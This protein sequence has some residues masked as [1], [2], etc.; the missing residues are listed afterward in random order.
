MTAQPARKSESKS[1]APLVDKA[2]N[3]RRFG[4]GI[5]MKFILPTGFVITTMMVV[6]GMVL[7][8]G[9][10]SALEASIQESGIFAASAAATPD[11]GKPDNRERLKSILTDRVEDVIIW[12]VAETGGEKFIASATGR[13]Q[14]VMADD[15]AGPQ[16]APG[17]AVRRGRMKNTRDEWIPYRSF[18]KAITAAATGKTIGSVEVLLSEEAIERDLRGLMTTSIVVTVI[19]IILAIGVAYFVAGRITRPLIDLIGDVEIVTQGDFKHRTR[20]RTNDEVGMLA[21]TFDRMTRELA[22]GIDMKADLDRKKHQEQ[23]AQEIQEKLLPQSLP[24]IPG[25]AIDAVFERSG[26][27]SGDL[28]D[29]VEV[30]PRHTGLLVMSASGH[31]VPAAIVLAMARSVFRA[32]AKSSV[33]PA[34]TLRRINALIA[35][36]LRRGMY[37]TAV[38]LVYDRD[39]HTVQIANAGHKMPVLHFERAQKKL[40]RVHPNGIAVGLDKG[41]V[42]D[43]SLEEAALE[44]AAGDA[45]LIGTAG[46]FGVTLADGAALG[47]QRYYKVALAVLGSGAAGAAEPIVAKVDANAAQ[48][49]RETDVTIVGLR[50]IE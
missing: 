48:T 28:F 12:E 18:K 29:Y 13:S 34:E 42:F 24:E 9:A 16:A 8:G 14:L 7:Y 31:G 39:A 21:E 10:A 40:A 46:I 27:I 32:V 49:E 37:V 20:A 5:A 26:E 2:S 50:R 25:L 43:K 3:R 41:P 19:G 22:A 1:Q 15:R 23:I 17:I 4:G 45:L 36:D 33:S 38:Y 47:D 30:S 35:P 6:L 44:L 11:W